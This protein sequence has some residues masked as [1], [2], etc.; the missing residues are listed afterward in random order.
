ALI[1]VIAAVLFGVLAYVSRLGPPLEPWH[2]YVPHELSADELDR[3]NWS[4]YMKAEG[5]IFDSVRTE[6]SQ[7]LSPGERTQAN[8]YFEG[9]P[10]YPGHFAR[11][12]N[13]SY[14]MEPDSSPV[15]AAVLLHGLTD[16]PYSMRHIAKLYRDAGYVSIVIRMPGHGTVPGGLTDIEWSQWLAA[17]RLAVREARRRVGPNLPLHLVGYSN[18]GALAVMYALD[19]LDDPRLA[20]P[21]RLILISPMIGITGFARFAGL[22]SLP[23]IFPPFAKAA[24][25]SIVPEFNPF[26]YNSF[27][28][29]AAR[30]SYLV[31]RALRRKIL[32]DVRDHRLAGLPPIITFQSVLDATVSTRALVSD[33]YAHL[34]ANGSE[35]VLFD[36][37]RDATLS[38]LLRPTSKTMITRLLP[39]PPRRYR[40]TIVANAGPGRSDVVERVTEAGA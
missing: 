27:P 36:V 5:A 9:S 2:T 17:T 10:I 38:P 31:T 1:A 24:W 19:A 3:A 25:L 23:A 26:K 16:S 13:R 32:R 34:P 37:N 4:D 22:A 30:Q 14:V 7:K 12:W 11:D 21:D 40:T 18:G 20:R 33:L 6:V 8:R 35:L 39:D 28:A 29:N 15:G